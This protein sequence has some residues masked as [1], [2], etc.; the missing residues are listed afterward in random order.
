MRDVY[1]YKK[2]EKRTRV[3]RLCWS[4]RRNANLPGNLYKRCTFS[5]K[6]AFCDHVRRVVQTKKRTNRSISSGVLLYVYTVPVCLY[7][8][9]GETTSPE[10]ASAP[11]INR[12]GS[13]VSCVF[14]F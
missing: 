14:G 11:E 6:F 8:G 4:I 5:G 13:R 3:C 10:K 12:G 9:A 7:F 2:E 1:V